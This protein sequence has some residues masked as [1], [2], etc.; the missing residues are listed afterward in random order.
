MVKQYEISLPPYPRGYHLITDHVAR[1]LSGLN[2]TGIVH[3]F[4][5]H[6]SAALSLNENAD[7]SV[8]EDFEYFMN[9]LI[10]ADDPGYTHVFEGDDDMS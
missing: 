3:V 7:P 9:K 2:V 4:I 8:R 1:V 5:K 10:P 6:T